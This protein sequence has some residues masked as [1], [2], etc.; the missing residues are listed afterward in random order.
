MTLLSDIRE[1]LT[2]YSWP[3]QPDVGVRVPVGWT[4][5]RPSNG[6]AFVASARAKK[7]AANGKY[8]LVVLN[9]YDKLSFGSSRP[10]AVYKMRC[11]DYEHFMY[12]FDRVLPLEVSSVPH[13]QTTFDVEHW[14]QQTL[15]QPT[16]DFIASDEET[17][18]FDGTQQTLDN[19]LDTYLSDKDTNRSSAE[20]DYSGVGEGDDE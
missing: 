6:R 12:H 2:E 4:L 18:L 10:S 11:I 1:V 3:G 14:V 9:M 15:F 5:L 17:M 20:S 7:S 13:E 16:P 19:A 8:V